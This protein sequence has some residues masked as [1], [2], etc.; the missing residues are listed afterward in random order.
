VA[1]SSGDL[2]TRRGVQHLD[3]NKECAYEH[4]QCACLELAEA[5]EPAST[6]RISGFPRGRGPSRGGEAPVNC[7]AAL[8]RVVM[9]DRL[10]LRFQHH[11]HHCLRDPTWQQISIDHSTTSKYAVW[12]NSER[13]SSIS[14][15]IPNH[16]IA[17][18]T[19]CCATV[20]AQTVTHIRAISCAMFY[21]STMQPVY[22]LTSRSRTASRI[23]GGPFTQLRPVAGT[24]GPV[25]QKV[26]PAGPP[27]AHSVHMDPGRDRRPSGQPGHHAAAP[28]ILRRRSWHRVAANLTGARW[29]TVGIAE[30][31]MDGKARRSDRRPSV[32]PRGT[33]PRSGSRPQSSS[34]CG[35]FPAPPRIHA[36]HPLRWISERGCRR[37]RPNER[38][39]GQ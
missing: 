6:R 22:Q 20:P 38:R 9:E 14:R 5:N 33:G 37:E 39:P 18:V 21:R 12:S 28:A 7:S 4:T 2:R 1:Q 17:K 26:Q 16:E 36:R 19:F 23:Y 8:V 32:R 11:R 10:D 25:H 30:C 13:L 29:G 34:P 35:G 15:W 31:P 27:V 24:S 3:D